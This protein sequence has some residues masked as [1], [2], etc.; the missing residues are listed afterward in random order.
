MDSSLEG[1]GRTPIPQQLFRGAEENFELAL[2]GVGYQ[3]AELQQRLRG[4]GVEDRQLLAFLDLVREVGD[5]LAGE[6]GR[7]QAQHT[8]VLLNLI[9]RGAMGDVI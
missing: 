4:N 7:R 8:P 6:V 2:P 1:R 3:R 5:V 9:W